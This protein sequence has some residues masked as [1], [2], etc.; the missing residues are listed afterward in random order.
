MRSIP[1]RSAVVLCA[2]AGS[3]ALGGCGDSGVVSNPG[4][5]SATTA[6]LVS[7]GAS[8]V[9]AAVDNLTPVVVKYSATTSGTA[10]PANS[11]NISA[12]TDVEAIAFDKNTGTTYV[13]G[14]SYT[15]NQPEI[16]AYASGATGTPTATRT[17]MMGLTTTTEPYDMTVDS[18]G[19]V[20]VVTVDTNSGLGTLLEYSATASGA[21]TPLKQIYGS[22]TG[23]V[24][25]VGVAVD[26]AG[27]VYVASRTGYNVYQGTI[28]AFASSANGNATP[29][30]T[31]T[32]PTNYFFNGVAVDSSLNVYAT[33][34][35]DGAQVSAP[36]AKIV[37]FAA[38]A[39]GTAT[40]AT[41]ITSPG[42]YYLGSLQV[43]A[44]K[45]IYA[46]NYY[47]QTGTEILG[48]GATASGYTTPAVDLTPV[49]LN[50]YTTTSL[51]LQ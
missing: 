39:S 23:I 31:I 46:I 49:A 42:M 21:A 37:K 35:Q 3:L 47:S 40:P 5:L 25:P 43:D 48:F 30:R 38:G 7:G 20:Y 34:E 16:W 27:M 51:A 10:I 11:I 22:A 18:A 1:V 32:A 44:V 9:Y 2:V 19:N 50:G 33:Q 4:S 26:S 28:L 17:I 6:P 12:T 45:N 36:N 14:F 8:S 13:T 15:D 24:T 29:T 41:T